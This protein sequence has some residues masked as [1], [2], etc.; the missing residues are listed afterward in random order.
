MMIETAKWDMA[1]YIKSPED[2]LAHLEAAFEDGDA[3]VIAATVGAIARA[4]GMTAVAKGAGITRDALYKSL[5]ADGDPRLSTVLGV[6]KALGVK[7][8]PAAS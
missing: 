7:L 2:E 6:M 8:T 1:D 5:V 4:R 3:G